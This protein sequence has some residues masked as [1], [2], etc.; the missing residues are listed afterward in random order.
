MTNHQPS[1]RSQSIGQCAS[2]CVAKEEQIRLGGHI[3]NHSLHPPPILQ[4]HAHLHSYKPLFHYEESN[5]GFQPNA[6]VGQFPMDRL[7]LSHIIVQL[8]WAEIA[9]RLILPPV[10]PSR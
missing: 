10:G 5:F 3:F 1:A 6:T 9:L 4:R 8:C 2:T 7:W